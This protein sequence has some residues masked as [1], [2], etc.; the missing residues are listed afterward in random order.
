MHTSEL[1]QMLTEWQSLG[2]RIKQYEQELLPLTRERSRASLASYRAGRG[3]LRLALDAHQQEIDFVIETWSDLRKR[4]L[5]K[6][7]E[8]FSGT[9]ATS[10][11]FVRR[12]RTNEA[13]GVD[14]DA[15]VLE[16][17]RQNRVSKL[18]P[19]GQKRVHQVCGDVMKARVPKVDAVLAMNF[20]Y[21]IFK[22]REQMRAYF[23]HVRKTMADDGILF[24]DAFGGYE[25]FKELTESRDSG[26]LTDLWHH[27]K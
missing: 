12:G 3:D 18:T 9:C 16:W 8:D 17:G 13:W 14:I 26:K 24:L 6:L 27:D 7:R 23:R 1:Q 15:D 19:G 5:R 25:A 20:S 21:W 4:P 11:E 2:E 22:T 10:C